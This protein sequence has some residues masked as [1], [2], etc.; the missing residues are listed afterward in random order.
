MAPPRLQTTIRT[1]RAIVVEMDVDSLRIPTRT[2]QVG[3]RPRGEPMVLAVEP[4]LILLRIEGRYRYAGTAGGLLHTSRVAANLLTPLAVVGDDLESVS[5]QLDT[6]LSTPTE[7][8]EVRRL[9]SRLESQIIRELQHGEDAS[10]ASRER[11]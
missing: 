9:L 2:G 3:I 5:R 1:P 11:S 7:E 4:G 10:L 8:M 6:L